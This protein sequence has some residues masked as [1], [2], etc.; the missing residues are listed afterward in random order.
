MPASTIACVLPSSAVSPEI[1]ITMESPLDLKRSKSPCLPSAVVSLSFLSCASRLAR[2]RT[3]AKPS[4]SGSVPSAGTSRTPTATSEP[5]HPRTCASV[6]PSSVASLALLLNSATSFGKLG[7]RAPSASRRF[8]A[9]DVE[10]MLASTNAT[11]VAGKAWAA[12]P[13]VPAAPA[14]P[15][16]LLEPPQPASASATRARAAQPGSARRRTVWREGV[17]SRTVEELGR[18]RGVRRAA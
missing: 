9:S 14:A 5:S 7:K 8:Q 2:S 4:T 13:S 17:I 12:R 11:V 15:L 1:A 18:I 3:S 6:G 10:S 16:A